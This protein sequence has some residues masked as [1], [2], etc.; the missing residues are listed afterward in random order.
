MNQVYANAGASDSTEAILPYLEGPGDQTGLPT[1]D[2]KDGSGLDWYVEGPGRRV[3]YDNLTAIDWIYEYAKERQRLRV[4]YANTVGLMGHFR[5]A[6][7]ASQIWVVLILAGVASG[8]VAAFIDIAGDWLADI[9]TGY[10]SNQA[11]GGRFYLSRGFCCFGYEE[12]AQCKDWQLWSSAWGVKNA[13]GSYIINYMLFVIFSVGWLSPWREHKINLW[14]VL[15]ATCASIL[16]RNFSI[17]AKHS[18][19]PEIKTVLGGFVIRRFM[20][21]WTLVTKSLGLVRHPPNE[22]LPICD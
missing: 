5:Q 17:Y 4:L 6:H 7:D 15:F 1:Q 14:Q 19:I 10:C 11:T 16:V 9:K 8:L 18:G 22:V 13:G 21:L 3:G 12:L 20:G 2:V